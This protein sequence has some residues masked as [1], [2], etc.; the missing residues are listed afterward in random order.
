MRQRAVEM[1]KELLA[2]FMVVLPR[3]FTV[4]DN[5]QK[6]LVQRRV[7]CD[8]LDAAHDVGSGGIRARLVVEKPEAVGQVAVTKHDRRLLAARAHPVGTIELRLP[9]PWLLHRV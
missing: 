6:H 3:I 4:Q 7:D 2:A 1:G 9:M 5:R 8:L